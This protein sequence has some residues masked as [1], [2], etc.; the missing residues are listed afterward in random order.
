MP[1]RSSTTS[2]REQVMKSIILL[3]LMAIAAPAWAQ[4]N[5]QLARENAELRAR[6]AGLEARMAQL[7]GR[8]APVAQ[9]PA[10]GKALDLDQ[11][12]R[13][14]AGLTKEQMIELLG[15]PTTEQFASA[16]N[17]YPDTETWYYGTPGVGPG[18]S[19][20]FMGGKVAQCVTVGFTN[21]P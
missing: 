18:G 7:E 12:R 14:R 5:E 20:M 15:K 2:K 3:T 21:N 17:Q 9:T 11:W 19:V 10:K 1:L 6:V 16:V 8:S 13:C 4:S